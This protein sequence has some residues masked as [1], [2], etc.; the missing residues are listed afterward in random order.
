MNETLPIHAKLETLTSLIKSHPVVIVAGETGS[1][2]STQLPQ[3]CY[4][5]GLT[6]NGRIAHT[7]PRRLAARTVASRVAE[8]LS[9]E[10]GSLVGCKMR[11]HDKTSA[12]TRIQLMTD[13]LLLAESEQDQLL[14]QYSVIIVDEAHE[15]SLNI[16]FLLGYLKQLLA[17]RNDLKLIIT[18][19]TIDHQ[20][21]SQHFNDAPIVEIEGRTFPVE[22]RYE[23]LLNEAGEATEPR[24][25]ILSNVR[26]LSK[27]GR[28]DI[29]VFL[30][31]ERDIF[32]TADFLRKAQLFNTEIMPLF[33]RLPIKQQ[34][35]IFAKSTKRKVV[36]ATNVAE[37][38]ITVPGIVYVIDAGLARMKRYNYRS[39]V[40]RLPIEPIS[41][42]SAN[43]RQGRCGRVAPGICVRLYSEEDFKSRPLFTEPEIL[44]SNLA[45]VILRMKLQQLGEI[46]DFPF[47][48]PPEETFIRDG[49]RLLHEIGALNNYH[50]L[51]KIGRQV[52]R[53]PLDPRLA[54]M[55]I[56]AKEKGVLNE[57]I[58]V[59][60]FLSVADP[61]IR[62]MGSQTKADEAHAAYRHKQSDFLS[63]LKLYAGIELETEAMTNRERRQYF[64]RNYIS[65]MR[66]K[67][68]QDIQRQLRESCEQI[69]KSKIFKRTIDPEKLDKHYANIHQAI[70]PG[71]LSHLGLQEEGALYQGARGLKFHVFPGSPLA[72]KPPKWVMAYEIVETGR[73]YA[74][75]VAKLD[76]TWVEAAAEHLLKREQFAPFWREAGF[77]GG[78]EKV[79]LYGLEVIAKRPINYGP[80][81]PK[82]AREIF[83]HHALVLG[84]TNESLD[85]LEANAILL[86]DLESFEHQQRASGLLVDET[87]RCA[88]FDALVPSNIY[89]MAD[90]KSWY[91]TADHQAF[92]YTRAF[93]LNESGLTDDFYPDSLQMG[94][95]SFQ[96]TYHFSPG[97][98]D[99]GVSL[100][101]PLPLISQV[102]EKSASWLVK[103]LLT[104]KIEE[105]LRTLP[106]SKRR[107]C[108]P[109]S[110]YAAALFERLVLAKRNQSLSSVL[111]KTLTEMTGAKFKSEDFDESALGSHLRMNFKILDTHG[112]VIQQ[113]RDLSILKGEYHQVAEEMTCEMHDD[114]EQDDIRHWDFGDLPKKVDLE[115][116]GTA[117]VAYPALIDAGDSV[118]IRAMSSKAKAHQAML[119]GLLR[120]FLLACPKEERYLRKQ[121]PG[122]DACWVLS[123]A[124]EMDFRDEFVETVFAKV[125]EL[126]K[127]F[128]EQATF[129]ERLSRK[130]RLAGEGASLLG[131]LH[132][133]FEGYQAIKVALKKKAVAR[134]SPSAF[135]DIQVQLEN[136]VYPGFIRHTPREWLERYP[137]YFKA[138]HCRIEKSLES[139]LKDQQL[140]LEVEPFWAQ[141]MAAD[142]LPLNHEIHY[143]LEEFRVSL[144]AQHLKTVAPISAKRLS[145]R[146]DSL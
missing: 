116:G 105:L 78:Y 44:R 68:W 11:F 45:S 42:A 62:P 142:N 71:V 17:K 33:A 73:V 102:D 15:R 89:T 25:A 122:S 139:V 88:F 130:T 136:L 20:R 118:Q 29:L 53:L 16:D 18:S 127:I 75:C 30:S 131:L 132:E 84:E 98:D 56:A 63:I 101:V 90:F 111:A 64:E 26:R 3:L 60:S 82:I 46:Q 80:I 137:T 74:R 87:H 94:D 85:F 27:E 143:W 40:E 57:I 51:T 55:V 54:R 108:A 93:L 19:A 79:M 129:E 125:F 65:F 7:Q 10:L 50:Q 124:T 38:S 58:L 107:L 134:K 5:M 31:T 23:P 4:Q 72:K 146:F 115:E 133:L 14:S 123:R 9:V 81:N 126:K 12:Q 66:F 22:T 140:Q 106:K 109:A 135:E 59:A 61:R 95:V 1:G 138:I 83:I 34:Q 117:Y 97:S 112:Q 36:L 96:L 76:P 103:P 92:Y 24:E 86:H 121:L 49:F 8:E 110:D 144:F 69:F 37:T 77:V 104:E 2:K 113:G 128:Y 120:L 52:S 21:F 67:E 43:Q 47:I 91:R 114:L 141:Y 48:E 70:L 35:A 13:G 100:N 32:D 28:G 119:S 6:E 145:Q 41:Q 99:D 39:K